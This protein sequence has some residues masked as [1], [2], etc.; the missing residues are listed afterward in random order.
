VPGL[1]QDLAR[2][3]TEFVASLRTLSLQKPPSI[4]ETLDWA[5]ALMLLG[6]SALTPALAADT[7]SLL[8]KHEDD[9]VLALPLA[10]KLP[11]P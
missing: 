11:K 8:L 3:L 7:L 10:D 2:Q 6:A 5:R 4:A 1:A 9:R